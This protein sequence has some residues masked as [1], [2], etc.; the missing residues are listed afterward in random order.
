MQSGSASRCG[1]MSL[2]P[3]AAGTAEGGWLNLHV[4]PN[5][6]VPEEGASEAGG[7]AGGGGEGGEGGIC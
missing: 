2:A 3:D 7:G 1:S 5:L 6:H 4:C